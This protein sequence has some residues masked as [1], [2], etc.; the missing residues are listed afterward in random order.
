V[1]RLISIKTKKLK[2]KEILQICRLKNTEWS[3]GIKS[4][5]IWFKKNIKDNDTHFLLYLKNTLIGYLSLRKKLLISKKNKK[6]YKKFFLLFD[7][8]IVKKRFRSKKFSYLIMLLALDFINK[9]KMLSVLICSKSLSTYYSRFNWKKI[10]KFDINV[11]SKNLK[12]LN[13]FYF[14]NKKKDLLLFNKSSQINL[15]INN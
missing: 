3:Y 9:K 11:K 2:E 8:F 10:S 7:T 12:G 6:I 5:F 13:V 15:F 4:Q 14:Q 1:I